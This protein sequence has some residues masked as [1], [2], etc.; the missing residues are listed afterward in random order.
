MIP[1][2]AVITIGSAVVG[3]IV[4]IM[5]N[6]Q[7]MVMAQIEAQVKLSQQDNQNAN[8]AKE[9]NQTPNSFLQRYAGLIIVFVGFVG[10]LIAMFH[11]SPVAVEV[12]RPVRNFLFW[13]WGGQSEFITAE[14]FVI[15]DYV[16]YS[17]QSLVGYLFG[18]SSA[19]LRKFF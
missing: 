5:G 17:V 15:P 10:L 19:K 18:A 4:T 2:D 3:G 9:R 6:N 1:I 8:D 11:G 7:K 12:T 16:R 14:G 13:T